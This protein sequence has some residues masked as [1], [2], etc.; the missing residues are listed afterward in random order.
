[1]HTLISC[2]LLLLILASA[3]LTENPL[4]AKWEGPY[5]GVPPF[6][7]V[8]IALFKPALEAAMAEQLAETDRIANNPA[9]PDFENTI[10][11]LERTGRTLDRVGILYGIWAGTMS[12]A[13]FQVVEREMAPKL[14][15]FNDKIN[16]NEPLF[17][18]IDAVYNSPAKARLTPEQQRLTWL[19]YTNFVRAGARLNPEAKKRLSEINQQLAGLFTKFSQNVLA[20]ENDQF[21]VLKTEDEL[22]GLPQSIRDAA[23]A[24]AEQKNQPGTWVIMNT[25]SSIDP[26]LTYSA[27][28]DLREKAWRM[29]V[30]RGDDGGEHDNNAIITDRK[31]TRLNS[32]HEWIS[33][34]PSSA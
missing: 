34:M 30:N 16:Q 12:N 8:Q 21:I 6:D 33:R 4:L 5:G 3:M 7:R 25:R 32:S 26:F 1:M 11:A 22:A 27:R 17:K 14:A 28:R 23:A 15:A 13:D 20:E 10:A 19:Y 31:S 24:A 18:R 9:A 2:G 29:F